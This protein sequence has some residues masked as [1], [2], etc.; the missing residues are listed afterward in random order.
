MKVSDRGRSK[1]DECNVLYTRNYMIRKMGRQ[2]ESK[3]PLEL[4]GYDIF[5][6][7]IVSITS[8]KLNNQGQDWRANAP[9]I[10]LVGYPIPTWS[11]PVYKWSIFVKAKYCYIQM[12]ISHEKVEH[13]SI[14]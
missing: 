14:T 12:C 8:V 5:S 2:V 3:D 7:L 6:I 4:A 13:K 1:V 11:W 9:T 10:T